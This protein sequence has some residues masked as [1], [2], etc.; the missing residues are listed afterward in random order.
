[1]CKTYRGLGYDYGRGWGV[2]DMSNIQKYYP[3]QGYTTEHCE[4]GPDEPF[5]RRILAWM[6]FLITISLV[7]KF[8]VPDTLNG[9]LFDL[10]N[11]I[12]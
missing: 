6:V 9:I 11:E 4:W 8:K 10:Q 12:P 5:S 2:D 1:M 3:T 7:N